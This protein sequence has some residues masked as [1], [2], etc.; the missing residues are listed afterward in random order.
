MCILLIFAKG[1]EDPWET[2]FEL[3]VA[4][5]SGL[6]WIN[7][8]DFNRFMYIPQV[9]PANVTKN[10][11]IFTCKN[12][13]LYETMLC[14]TWYLNDECYEKYST[15]LSGWIIDYHCG[16]VSEFDG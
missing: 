2:N 16:C 13:P 1:S 5:N 11:D 12:L 7:G 15:F 10:E 6:V 4:Q 14:C 3:L 8:N 9:N